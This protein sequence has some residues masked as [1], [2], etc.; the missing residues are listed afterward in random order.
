[1]PET[2]KPLIEYQDLLASA[3]E[4]EPLPTSAGRLATL[5]ADSDTD[6]AQITEVVSFDQSLTATLLR[7][8]NSAALGARAPV[9]TVHDAVVRLGPASLLALSLSAQVS[10]RMT[11]AIPAYGLAEGELWKRSVAASLTADVLRSRAT[12]AVPAEA[13]TAALLHDFGRVVLATHFGHQVLDM[14]AA[15]ADTE[16]RDLQE[17]EQYLFGAT[18]A[19]IG[20]IVAQHWRLPHS[21]VEAIVHHHSVRPD[22]PPICLV[23]SLAHGMCGDVIADEPPTVVEVSLRVDTHGPQLRALGL[24][25]RSYPDVID[26][27]R[28][29]FAQLADLY[30]AH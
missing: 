17:V 21:I 30:D 22:L 10:R 2:A 8:A 1:M 23:V 9:R 27:A 19:D 4:I 14:L 24:D 5:V 16:G 12:V 26:L 11:K 18:H 25:P 13:G 3:Q 7:T 15:A 28:T 29:R 20:G 6:L